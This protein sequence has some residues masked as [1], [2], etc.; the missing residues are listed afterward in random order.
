MRIKHSFKKPFD[1]LASLAALGLYHAATPGFWLLLLARADPS[2]A[3]CRLEGVTCLR[4]CV[5]NQVE[6]WLWCGWV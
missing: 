1:V 3:P 5:L 6:M 2:H 4:R